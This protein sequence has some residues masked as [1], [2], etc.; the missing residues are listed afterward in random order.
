MINGYNRFRL[1]ELWGSGRSA[2]ADGTKW[3]LYEQNLLSEYHIRYGSYGGVGYYV[4]SDQYIALFS[5]F[6]SCGVR[7]AVFILD[8]LLQNRSDITA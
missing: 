5:H 1:P 7:E 2:S 4:I 8:G 6:I 3:D